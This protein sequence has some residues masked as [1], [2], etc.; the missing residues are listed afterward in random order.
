[1]I[2]Y[3]PHP[4]PPYVKVDIAL[5]PRLSQGTQPKVSAGAAVPAAPTQT[6]FTPTRF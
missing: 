3:E 6:E 2:P 1:M 4:R 5:S